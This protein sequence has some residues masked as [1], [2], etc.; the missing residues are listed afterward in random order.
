MKTLTALLLLALYCANGSAQEKPAFQQGEGQAIHEKKHSWGGAIKVADKKVPLDA[1][2][3]NVIGLAPNAYFCELGKEVDSL[4]QI[5]DPSK[6][7]YIQASTGGF[8]VC[9][10]PDFKE[11]RIAIIRFGHSSYLALQFMETILRPE[12]ESFGALYPA[13][14]GLKYKWKYW[15]K[16]LATQDEKDRDATGIKTF[17]MPPS[18]S[19]Y[20]AGVRFS[21]AEPENTEQK[22]LTLNYSTLNS[23]KSLEVA[24]PE[25]SNL[26][27]VNPSE[28]NFKPLSTGSGGSVSVGLKTAALFRINGRQHVAIEPT[29]IKSAG[30]VISRAETVRLIRIATEYRVWKTLPAASLAKNN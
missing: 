22:S 17:E 24:L 27:K 11:H 9:P 10:K 23:V 18:R 15:P 6:F 28:C 12:S 5:D 13:I 26:A 2:S 21:W 4:D 3:S 1:G 8:P 7:K 25:E 14:D 16:V 20:L 19:L 30:S 29:G